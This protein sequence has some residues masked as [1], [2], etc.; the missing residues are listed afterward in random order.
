MITFNAFS[1]KIVRIRVI[2]N[3]TNTCFDTA[4]PAV[5][6]SISTIFARKG[7]EGRVV[8]TI[9]M[10]NLWQLPARR[11]NCCQGG[12]WNEMLRQTYDIDFISCQ[13]I[14][15]CL[16][17]DISFLARGIFHFLPG[18]F[19]IIC[20]RIFH[21]LPETFFIVCQGIFHSLPEDIS[22]LARDIFHCL[23]GD[24]SFLARDIFHNC[25]VILSLFIKGLTVGIYF[26]KKATIDPSSTTPNIKKLYQ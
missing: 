14:F 12:L 22:F 8:A 5:E 10:I 18:I 6:G 19:F 3:C 13:D 11:F 2:F 20:Q 23:P 26:Q 25:L 4:L 9:F 21:S 7:K 15:H 17:E 16:P 24:I 1:K